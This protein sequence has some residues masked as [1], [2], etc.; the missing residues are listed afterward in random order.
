MLKEGPLERGGRIYLEKV[1][2]KLGLNERTVR[3]CQEKG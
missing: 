3:V 2:P 1:M